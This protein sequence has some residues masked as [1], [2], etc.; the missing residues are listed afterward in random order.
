VDHLPPPALDGFRPEAVRFASRM[1]TMKA[2]EELRSSAVF[3]EILAGL[4]EASAPLDLLAA[5]ANIVR[6]EVE[7]AALCRDLA[8]RF[9]A[10]KPLADISLALPRLHPQGRSRKI[11]ALALLLFEGAVGETISSMLFHASKRATEEPC[12]KA[13]LD[14]ILRDEARHARVSWEGVTVMLPATSEGE[15][16]VLQED[17]RQSF[18]ALERTSM[19]PLLRRLEQG[20]SVDSEVFALGVIPPE[21]RAETFYRG[22]ENVVVPRLTRAG[23]DGDRAWRDRHKAT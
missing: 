1:W 19:L 15:R 5:I 6:D 3:V 13:A 7:H 2:E 18:G 16:C 10:P 8:L 4:A 23:F 20:I 14:S 21:V 12:S 17:L 22:V 11:H 9:G